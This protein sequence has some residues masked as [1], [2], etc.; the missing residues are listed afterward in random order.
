VPR[1]RRAGRP[2]APGPAL[3]SAYDTPHAGIFLLW[4]SVREL[5]LEAM[6]PDTDP[7]P[8]ALT[9]AATLAGPGRV[10]AWNDPALHWLA[11]YRPGSRDRPRIA[12][13]GMAARFAALM[14]EHA[15]PRVVAQMTQRAKGLAIDQDAR[16]EDWLAVRPEPGPAVTHGDCRS[17]ARDIAFFGL[18]RAP[19]RRPWALL[20]RAAYADF[21]RRLNGLDRSTAAW[22]WTNLLGGWGRIEPGEPARLVMPRV[23]LDLVL[24]MTGL[25]GARFTLGD[26]RV[27]EVRL[28]GRGD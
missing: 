28:A 27:I 7:G 1:P 25:D 19:R 10:A 14:A 26:G 20:A 5:G 3:L 6:F 4:R 21:A 2:D 12:D 17:P 11:G 8:A 22:L 15:R 18:A 23:P 13:R 16:T 24:R 9:L